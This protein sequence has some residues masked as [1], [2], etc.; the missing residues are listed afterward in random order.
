MFR[1]HSLFFFR[2][3]FREWECECL[4]DHLAEIVSPPYT[5]LVATRVKH[6]MDRC[7]YTYIL[8]KPRIVSFFYLFTAP[9]TPAQPSP[10][11]SKTNPCTTNHKYHLFIDC[12][13]LYLY[14][15]FLWEQSYIKYIKNKPRPHQNRTPPKHIK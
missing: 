4:P 14:F 8:S 15:V 10:A 9:Y 6:K 11:Q 5:P 2:F 1:F 7:L 12:V 13:F 3:Y